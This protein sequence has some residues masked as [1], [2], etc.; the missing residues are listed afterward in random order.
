MLLTQPNAYL[1]YL[2]L[3]SAFFKK[4]FQIVYKLYYSTFLKLCLLYKQSF[5]DFIHYDSFYVLSLL[6]ITG[7]E[8]VK[9]IWLIIYKKV[10]KVH[11]IDF[12]NLSDFIITKR[13]IFKCQEIEHYLNVL[14]LTK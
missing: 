5:S 7:K 9:L 1:L 4:R 3:Q 14:H 6:F 13:E 12:R 11:V 8:K 10:P 2:P